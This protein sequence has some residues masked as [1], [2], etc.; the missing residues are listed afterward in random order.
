MLLVQRLHTVSSFKSTINQGEELDT[1]LIALQDG[2]H[3]KKRAMGQLRKPQE[4]AAEPLGR[5]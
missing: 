5:K 2:T 3:S 1:Y 4:R